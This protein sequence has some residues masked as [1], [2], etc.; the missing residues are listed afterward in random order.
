[1][2]KLFDEVKSLDRRCYEKFFLNEDILME[3]AAEGMASYI[4]S[5]FEK[6]AK[7]IIVCGIG[8]NGADG[9]ALARLLQGAYNVFIYYVGV[10]K[11]KMAVLQKKRAKSVG[12]KECHEIFECDVLVDAIAGT[13]FH[14]S[15]DDELSTLVEKMNEAKAFKIACDIPSGY[16]FF[17]DAT[18]TMGALKKSMFLDSAK[19]YIGE[20]KVIDLGVSRE[21]Y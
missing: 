17:A 12:V 5:R 9:M 10:P 16:R 1:M 14:G 19:D 8:N 20:I 6:N 3:H 13:G 18:L 2:Q 4:R 21:I 7:I 11:S 15:F